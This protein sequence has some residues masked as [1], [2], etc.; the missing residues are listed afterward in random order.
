MA[1]YPWESCLASLFLSLLNRSTCN[2]V[3]GLAIILYL[4][5]YAFPSWHFLTLVIILFIDYLF[6]LLPSIW[7]A[8]KN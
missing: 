8:A 7:I 4:A 3:L 1:V 2:L 6:R 5:S